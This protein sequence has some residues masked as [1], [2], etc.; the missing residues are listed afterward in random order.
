[1]ITEEHPIQR[2]KALLLRLTLDSCQP[3]WELVVA[4]GRSIWSSD[5]KK[6]TFQVRFGQPWNS[7]KS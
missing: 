2:S 4:G 6:N 5:K 1:M 7:H 3:C